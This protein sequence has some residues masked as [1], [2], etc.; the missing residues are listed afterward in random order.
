MS[1]RNWGFLLLLALL[2]GSSFFF[3]K[4]LVA[5][6]PPVTV[7]LGRV[8]IAAIAMNL[9]LLAQGTVMPRQARLWAR[10]LLLGLLNNVI[11]F[12]LIA[13]G[14]TR[15]SS[16]MASILNATTP[17]FMVAVAHFGTQDEKL[18]WAKI[19]GIILGIVGV[20]VLMGRDAFAGGGYVWGGLAV[21]G[22]SCAY[23][24]GGVYSRRFRDLS[25]MQAATGQI[26][27]GAILLLPLSLLADHP[28]TLPM[29]GWAVW[30]SLLAIAL[31]NT[32]LAYFIYFKMV[33]TVGV[34]YISLVTF[35]I[36]IIA[37]L[38]GAAFLDE[39]VTAQALA[40]MAIIA[41]GLAAIDGRL[42]RL[43]RRP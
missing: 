13:W 1:A 7:V 10:F 38:L 30:S 18:S 33:A 36:P 4:I 8:G 25:P 6:L 14:E 16:G 15:I 32:A 31:V 9:W 39:S 23:G 27:G 40:G 11:P 12:V 34:T 20:A 5:V 3:Y 29:P 17:I 2:W 37:L 26:T 43:G 21:I 28:W 41:L 19:A 35:L 22:A 42:F 24:F